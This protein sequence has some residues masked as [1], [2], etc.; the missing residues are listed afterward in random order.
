LQW[1]WIRFAALIFYIGLAIPIA[2]IYAGQLVRIK[3]KSFPVM[4]AFLI[5]GPLGILFYNLF[6]A[7]GP[8]YV[9][10]S[11]PLDLLPL[12]QVRRLLLEPISIE[13]PRNAI[14]SLHMAW[15]LLA[16]WYS[17]GLSWWERVLAFVFIAFTVL[18]TLGTGEHWFVDLVVAFPFALLIQA[19]CA[20]PVS[21]KD[22]RRL[23]AFLFGLL[24]TVT[25]FVALRYA[26]KLFWASPFVPWTLVTSTIALTCILQAKLAGAF[27]QAPIPGISVVEPIRETRSVDGVLASKPL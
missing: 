27:S 17:R 25:W 19:I 2:V 13:G 7:S 9:F 21:W 24:G 12:D 4:L 20:Y 6:P 14:P 1:P 3:E 8:R 10:H 23:A 16:W 15:T 26:E 5:T 22:S 18:A 11:F